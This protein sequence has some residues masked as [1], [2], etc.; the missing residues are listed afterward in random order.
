MTLPFAALKHQS[1]YCKP[2]TEQSTVTLLNSVISL[3]QRHLHTGLCAGP[4]S[5][6]VPPTVPQHFTCSPRKQAS[7]EPPLLRSQAL[8]CKRT[9]A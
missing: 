8:S 2:A 7:P 6:L 3:F 1:S 4:S 9:L 5:G